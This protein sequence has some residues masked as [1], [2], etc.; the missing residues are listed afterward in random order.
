MSTQIGS[1]T[2]RDPF[3][4]V[5]ARCDEHEG[6]KDR[7]EGAEEEDEDEGE[8]E[9]ERG[10]VEWLLKEREEMVGDSERERAF[11]LRSISSN[12]SS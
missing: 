6:D 11:L 12:S 1:V 9:E 5:T 10:E 8:T 7:D 4:S 3:P 2:F